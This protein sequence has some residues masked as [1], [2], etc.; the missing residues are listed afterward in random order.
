[1]SNPVISIVVP[2]YNV[3]NFL[4]D[5]I[6]SVVKQ[7]LN[8][9]SVSDSVEVIL[10]DDGSTDNSADLCDKWAATYPWIK[11]LHKSNGG[12][13]SARRAISV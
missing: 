6:E 4:D 1:M 2:V 13:I 11:S 8:G 5:C 9:R 7:D 3:G 12:V 10:V